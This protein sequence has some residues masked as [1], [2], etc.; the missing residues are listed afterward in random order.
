[1]ERTP[2]DFLSVFKGKEVIVEDKKA[3]QITGKLVAFDLNIN[4]SLI[5]DGTLEFV[6]GQNIVMVMLKE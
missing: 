5:V 6:Q 4:L 3:R 1:M 2:L